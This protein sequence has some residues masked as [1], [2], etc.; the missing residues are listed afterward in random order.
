[1]SNTYMSRIVKEQNYYE[2]R[3]V[4]TANYYTVRRIM[5]AVS[6]CYDV[7]KVKRLNYYASVIV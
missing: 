3:I 2:S 5:L 4:N 1:M 7:I 6:N